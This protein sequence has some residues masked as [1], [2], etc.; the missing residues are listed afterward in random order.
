MKRNS[1]ALIIHPYKNILLKK[2]RMRKLLDTFAIKLLDITAAHPNF[3]INISLPGYMLHYLDPLL[4]TKLN[5]LNK[6]SCLEWLTSGYT[7]PFLGFSPL[8][9]SDD[10]VKYGLETYNELV[11][12]K[13]SGY[14]PAFSN[15]EPSSIA[16][17]RNFGI[18]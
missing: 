7:E 2:D 5:E 9:L 18:S 8:W 4:L 16:T 12:N 11:G 14:I 10:N 3:R 6:T 17:L 13:P 1:L 15:W